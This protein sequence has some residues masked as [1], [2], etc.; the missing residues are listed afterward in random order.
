MALCRGHRRRAHRPGRL[1]QHVPTCPRAARAAASMP[2]WAQRPRPAGERPPPK[3]GSLV[4]SEDRGGAASRRLVCGV[5]AAPITL[6]ISRPPRRGRS[7]TVSCHG[8]G[9]LLPQGCQAPACIAQAVLTYRCRDPFDLDSTPHV[10]GWASG[11]SLSPARTFD[12]GLTSTQI[13]SHA[14]VCDARYASSRRLPD[15]RV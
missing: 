14:S 8:D 10:L 15:R 7:P 11:S 5:L 12:P 3:R 13:G 6:H 1:G 2:R 9:R 4:R